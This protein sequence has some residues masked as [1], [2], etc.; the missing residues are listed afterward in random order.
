[1]NFI[2]TIPSTPENEIATGYPQLIVTAQIQPYFHE[3]QWQYGESFHISFYVTTHRNVCHPLQT[4]DIKITCAL[5]Y[6]PGYIVSTNLTFVGPLTAG[7]LQARII[8]V[9]FRSLILPNKIV[10]GKLVHCKCMI[11][12]QSLIILV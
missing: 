1:M 6:D 2:D 8:D 12:L 7:V 9:F 5:R 11:G 3:V 4:E 10:R